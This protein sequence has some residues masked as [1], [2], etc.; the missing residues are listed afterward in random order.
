MKS[1]GG[2]G[3]PNTT[4][5]NTCG[6]CARQVSW[7]LKSVESSG[8]TRSPLNSKSSS[9]RTITF[10]ILVAARFALTSCRNNWRDVF[11]VASCAYVCTIGHTFT[12]K[13]HFIFSLQVL[14][15]PHS[16]G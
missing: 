15:L 7:K 8:S 2:G 13:F 16:K 14:R 12:I 4:F 1:P 11:L 6:S 3:C 5:L 9:Q 10:S